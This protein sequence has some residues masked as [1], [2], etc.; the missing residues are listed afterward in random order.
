MTKNEATRYLMAGYPVSRKE[1]GYKVTY[2]VMETPLPDLKLQPPF[3]SMENHF[4]D[5]ERLLVSYDWRN[6][7]MT[8]NAKLPKGTYR[9]EK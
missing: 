1:D 5:L 4:D 6:M 7:R 3:T 2:I 8:F 9:L